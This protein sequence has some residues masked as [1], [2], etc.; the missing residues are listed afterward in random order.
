M[1]RIR[2]ALMG[3]AVAVAMGT[4]GSEVAVAAPDAPKVIDLNKASLDELLGFE[5]IGRAY[6]AKIVAARPFHNRN[7]L[8]L[9][10]VL[11]TPVYLSIR[12][13]LYVSGVKVDSDGLPSG[14]VPA[15]MLDLNRASVDQLLSVSGIGRAYAEKIVAARPYRSELE[16]VGRRV[17][18]MSAYQRVAGKIAVAN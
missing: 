10:N 5:G 13:R 7:E 14:T 15:G 8:V 11:P 1:R 18:P 17:M 12:H 16:L 2:L 6:A 3:I 9:R 4:A